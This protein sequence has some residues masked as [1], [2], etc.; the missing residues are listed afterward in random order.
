MAPIIPIIGRL[1][2]WGLSIGG[3][4][5]GTKKFTEHSE[6]NYFNKGICPKCGGHFKH[7]P[8]TEVKGSKGYKCDFCDNCVW[9]SFGADDGYIYTPSKYAKRGEK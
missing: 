5:I 1:I 2:F 3:F 7:I 6:R 9:I 8:R 4:L